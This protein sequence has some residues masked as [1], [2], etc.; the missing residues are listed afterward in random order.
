MP[1][2]SRDFQ[3]CNQTHFSVKLV[4]KMRAQLK[5]ILLVHFEI[6]KLKKYIWRLCILFVP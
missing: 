2:I 5:F 3:L 6:S 4:M 1:E